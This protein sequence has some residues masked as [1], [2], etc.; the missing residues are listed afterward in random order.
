MRYYS[1]VF[2][3]KLIDIVKNFM[4]YQYLRGHWRITLQFTVLQFTHYEHSSEEA[5]EVLVLWFLCYG[6]CVM[7]LVLWF[8][9]Y[10][11][12]VMVLVLWFYSG[13]QRFLSSYKPHVIRHLA[14]QF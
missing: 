1:W 9:C 5:I 13:Y 11:S 12:C 8:L 4:A 14:I 10:G 3:V 7:V 6:S 2:E